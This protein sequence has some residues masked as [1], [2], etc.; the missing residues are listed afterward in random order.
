MIKLRSVIGIATL[1]VVA[2][3]SSPISMAAG[4]PWRIECAQTGVVTP[5]IQAGRPFDVIGSGFHAV[6][7]PI[8]VCVNGRSCQIATPNKDGSF[9]VTRS[10]T[11]PGVYMIEA[12]QARDMKIT[13]WRLRAS[14][15]VAV[16]N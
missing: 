10:F 9:L 14:E 7:L 4:G 15:Q 16:N 8:K 3:I 11:T 2:V 1:G 12:W 5:A 13:E 6:V